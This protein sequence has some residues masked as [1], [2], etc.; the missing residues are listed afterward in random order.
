M[1]DNCGFLWQG[2]H[3]EVSWMRNNLGLGRGV[4]AAPED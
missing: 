3:T 4:A 1:L 2:D